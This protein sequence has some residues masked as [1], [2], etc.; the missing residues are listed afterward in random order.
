MSRISHRLLILA[1]AGQTGFLRREQVELEELVVD[2]AR[3]WGSTADRRWHIESLTDGWVEVDVEQLGYALDALVENALRFTVAGDSISLIAGI[4]ADTGIIEVSDSGRGI[5]PERVATV[6]ER[7]QRSSPGHGGGGAGLGLPMVRAIAEAHG[8]SVTVAASP[9]GGTVFRIAL[10]NVR[11][12]QPA[13]LMDTVRMARRASG[14]RT[15][16]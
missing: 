16:A 4:E 7:F 9:A 11:T 10:P 3:R 12:Q 1:A 8:G 13:G 6:F 15:V 14:Q 2:C 5:D